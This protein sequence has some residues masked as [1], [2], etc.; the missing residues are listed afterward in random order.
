MDQK[1]QSIKYLSRE[2]ALW[3]KISLSSALSEIQNFCCDKVYERMMT[4][5]HDLPTSL[6][7]KKVQKGGK[8]RAEK[9]SQFERGK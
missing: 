4:V 2:N 7:A 8:S 9:K 6:M 3:E 5:L 1:N